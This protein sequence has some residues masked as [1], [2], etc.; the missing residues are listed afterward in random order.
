MFEIRSCFVC[1]HI[2]VLIVHATATCNKFQTIPF[3]VVLLFIAYRKKSAEV[4]PQCSRLLAGEQESA[5]GDRS[6]SAGRE[7]PNGVPVGKD[8]APQTAVSLETNAWQ[9]SQ[10]KVSSFLRWLLHTA[11]LRHTAI[12]SPTH[13][14]LLLVILPTH[15]SSTRACTDRLSSAL[16]A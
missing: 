7:Q 6:G 1:Y 10:E 13:S 5:R 4:S 2:T 12:S 15:S 16:P 3:V 11:M 14:F 8:P 9:L